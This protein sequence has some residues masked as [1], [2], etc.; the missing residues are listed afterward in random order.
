MNSRG[1][2]GT[3]FFIIYGAN[4]FLISILAYVLSSFLRIYTLS[5]NFNILF[6]TT[7]TAEVRPCVS[8]RRRGTTVFIMTDMWHSWVGRFLPGKASVIQ[9]SHPMEASWDL[10]NHNNFTP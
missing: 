3:Y 4:L 7:K 8:E 2:Y 10:C 5:S 9:P 1:Y 6:V